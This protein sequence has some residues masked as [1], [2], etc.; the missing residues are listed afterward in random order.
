MDPDLV[1]TFRRI[2]DLAAPA[3]DDWWIIGSAAVALHG[4]AVGALKDVDLL[5]SERDAAAF[6]SRLGIAPAP[7]APDALF[8]S[9][10]RGSWNGAPVPVDVMGGFSFAAAEGWRVLVLSTREAIAVGDRL[11]YV[12]AVAELKALL[13]SFGREKDLAR[14]A[15]LSAS[16]TARPAGPAASG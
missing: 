14:A 13:L 11:L 8:R 4:G 6:L 15:L 1:E 3:R 9:R 16:A 12:P 5:M 10:V 2:A 7:G